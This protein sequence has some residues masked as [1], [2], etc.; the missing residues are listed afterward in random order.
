[1]SG[2]LYTVRHIEITGRRVCMRRMGLITAS[3]ILLIGVTG[4]SLFPT[5]ESYSWG[6]KEAEVTVGEDSVEGKLNDSIVIDAKITELK[7][8]QWKQYDVS[9]LKYTSEEI[10]TI[11]DRLC[12]NKKLQ[13]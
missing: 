6:E 9:L 10:K 3:I 5:G 1:M 8:I 7:N 12:Q 2:S 4:C 11:A 13:M